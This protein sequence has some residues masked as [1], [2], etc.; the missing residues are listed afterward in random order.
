MTG[1][2]KLVTAFGGKALRIKMIIPDPELAVD[3]CDFTAPMNVPYNRISGG[4]YNIMKKVDN[5]TYQ[6]TI[7]PI[8]DNIGGEYWLGDY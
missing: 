1:Y 8:A 5:T 2:G 3:G 7:N 4:N 6:N